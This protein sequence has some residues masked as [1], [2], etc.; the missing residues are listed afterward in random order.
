M[1][2]ISECIF[3][4]IIIAILCGITGIHPFKFSFI[5]IAIYIIYGYIKSKRLIIFYWLIKIFFGDILYITKDRNKICITESPNNGDGYY[6]EFAKIGKQTF[7]RII[8]KG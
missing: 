8:K 3:L 2:S 1:N 7:L 5:G 4:S 6:F